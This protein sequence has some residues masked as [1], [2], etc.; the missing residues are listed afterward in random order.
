[1]K[2]VLEIVEMNVVDVVTTSL[3]GDDATTPPTCNDD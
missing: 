3:C 1:M 2:A